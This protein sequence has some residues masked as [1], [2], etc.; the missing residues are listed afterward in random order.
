MLG[1]TPI[2]AELTFAIPDGAPSKNT[3]PEHL[4]KFYKKFSQ[5]RNNSYDGV[6]VTGAPVEHLPFEE[7]SYWAELEDI[8]DWIRERKSA[9]YSICWGAMAALHHYFRI[10]KH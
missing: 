4:A 6:V 9:L 3:P 8:F 10:P 2:T 7:V 5:V 1:Q